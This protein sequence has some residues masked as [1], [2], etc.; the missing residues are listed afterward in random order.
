MKEWDSRS[1]EEQLGSRTEWGIISGCSLTGKTTVAGMIAGLNRGKIL[2]MA[3]LS[4]ECKKRLGTEDEPFEGD[5][6]LAEVEKDVVALVEADKAASEQ[7]TYI[8]DGYTHTSAEEFV[9]WFSGHFGSPSFILKLQADK[10]IIEDRY[11][12]RNEVEGEELNEDQQAELAEMKKKAET[13]AKQFAAAI[14]ECGGKTQEIELSTDA[15]LESTLET[16]RSKFCAK[17]ILV[18]H[19]KRLPVDTACCNL[20]I[21]YN[22]LYLSVYQLIKEQISKNT[23]LGQALAAS[24]KPKALVNLNPTGAPRDAFEEAEYSAV[25]FD[26]PIVM[27]LIQETI[28][29]KRTNQSFILLEGLCNSSK[30][31]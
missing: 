29:E 1:F 11:R 18:N 14:A 23:K 16:L 9:K 31:A 28:M 22:M 13:E 19:E 4:E 24:K 20:A 5:V 30:L 26:L 15:S 10:P 12:K 2:N 21:K 8:F 3:V 7:F 25:H 17:V 6:P 27:Q